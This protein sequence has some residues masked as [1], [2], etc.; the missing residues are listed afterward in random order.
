MKII[1]ISITERNGTFLNYILI[2]SKSGLCHR[3]NLMGK[4]IQQS[5]DP[6]F[7]KIKKVKYLKDRVSQISH[8]FL[9]IGFFYPR[10]AHPL[11]LFVALS[12]LPPPNPPIITFRCSNIF[13]LPI[14]KNCTSKRKNNFFILPHILLKQIFNL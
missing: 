6:K 14:F 9:N 11:K 5:W 13:K 1:I 8:I 3:H 2:H 10:R 7:C 4:N 12:L